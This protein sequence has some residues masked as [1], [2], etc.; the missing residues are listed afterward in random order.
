MNNTRCNPG[1]RAYFI[2][3][4]ERGDGVFIAVNSDNG[5]PVITRVLQL[6][7]EAHGGGLPPLF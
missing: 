7:G 4:L 3:A 1:F 5:V 2:V 6:W